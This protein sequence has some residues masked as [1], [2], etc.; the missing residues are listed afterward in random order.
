[1]AYNNQTDANRHPF[2]E[3]EMSMS[4][5]HPSLPR[6]DLFQPA[7]LAEAS[8]FLSEHA[9]DAR[10]FLG[11]TDL[12]V[13]MRDGQLKP[14]T[15]VNL[16]TIP[17]MNRLDFEPRDG[18]TI[19]GAVTMNRVIGFKDA[20]THYPLLVEAVRS[21]ASYQLR[22]RAT[23]VGNICN[24]S[25]AGDTIGAALLYQGELKVFS[26][27]GEKTV[28]LDDFFLAPGKTRLKPGEIVT[29]LHLPP[30]PKGQQGRYCKLGRNVI[31]DL[32]IVGVA[33]LGFA[34]QKCKSGFRFR[35]AVASAASIPLMVNTAAEILA[36]QPINETTIQQAAEA[37]RLACSPI[38]DVRSSATYRKAMVERCTLRAISDVWQRLQKGG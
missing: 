22:N 36:S 31:S 3:E 5:A 37:A 4:N 25:P 26:A 28:P 14:A 18:L 35:I 12:F 1:L 23:I 17:D 34:D 38:D 24:A 10:P 11:G 27:D 15:L 16:K 8:R 7:N 2:I 33:V 9:A 21:V 20:Q 13:R 6:F 30:A 32:S 29:S 19:G